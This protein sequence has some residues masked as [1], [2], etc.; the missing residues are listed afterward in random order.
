MMLTHGAGRMLPK[1]K[2]FAVFRGRG[3]FLD[4]NK[5]LRCNNE[6]Q[7]CLT[8]WRCSKTQPSAKTDTEIGKPIKFS[9]SKG[10]HRSWSVDLSMGSS[11]QR[12]WWKVLPVG[13]FTFGV[14]LWCM[15]GEDVVMDKQSEEKLHKY[16]PDILPENYEKEAKGVS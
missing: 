13:I 3:L 15:F 5:V 4:G 12:P 2:Y 1:L 16:L 11:F 14:L 7:L 8:S 10:S 6:R 9:T